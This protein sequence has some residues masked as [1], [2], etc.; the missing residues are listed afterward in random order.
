MLRQLILIDPDHTREDSIAAICEEDFD[1]S[2]FPSVERAIDEIPGLRP[3]GIIVID[4]EQPEG[5]IRA[6]RAS[7]PAKNLPI[8][9]VSAESS[10]ER[11]AQAFQAG[12][13][14]Y[15]CKASTPEV[16][17]GRVLGS[18]RQSFVVRRLESRLKE[19]DFLVRM[20]SHDLKNPIG[21]ILS[22][23][24][25][26]ECAV[27]SG[28]AAEAA[29]LAATIHRSCRNALEFLDDLLGFLRNGLRLSHVDLVPA[30]EVIRAALAELQVKVEESRASVEVPDDLPRI[31]CDRRRM[32]QVFTNLIGNA[33]KYVPGG[34]PLA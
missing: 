1:L 14:D 12:A 18:L 6:L 23:S 5:I 3:H 15:I 29:D 22:C 20:V 10:A 19:M 17:R 32:V 21:S 31:P 26:L 30:G 7:E 24:E 28:D 33:M 25:L 4:D 8:V 16:I 11:E 2:V 34:P 27:G 9:V 13:D